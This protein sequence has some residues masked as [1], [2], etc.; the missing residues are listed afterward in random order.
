ML[1]APQLIDRSD[2]AKTPEPARR[3]WT[4][5]FWTLTE[6]VILVAPI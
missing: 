3:F 4:R 6:E 1:G 2:T 5:R